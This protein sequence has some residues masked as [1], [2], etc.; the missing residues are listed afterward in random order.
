[1]TALYSLIEAAP[2]ESICLQTDNAVLTYGAFRD[3]VRRLSGGLQRHGLRRGD[4]V[5]VWLPNTIDWLVAALAFARAGIQVLGINIRFGPSE[6]GDF[7]SRATC[8]ALV[9]AP[10]HAGKDYDAVLRCIPEEQLRSLEMAVTLGS[11]SRVLANVRSFNFDELA[12]GEADGE[13]QAQG[14]DPCIVFSSSGTTSRPKL[15]IHSQERLA[16]HAMDVVR[17]FPLRGPGARVLVGV[18][19]CGAFGYTVALAGLAGHC[20]ITAPES[21]DA[22]LVVEMLDGHGITHMFGTNDMLQ[23]MLDVAGLAWRPRTLQ[24]FAHANFTPGLTALPARAEAQ[25]VH[26]RGCFGMSETFALFATQPADAPLSRRAESGGIPNCQ[27]AA[28]RVRN[29]E[30][31]ELQPAGRQGELEIFSP[32][33]ML[34]YLGDEA[35][36]AK[37]FTED[38]FFRT[39]DLAYLNDDGGFTHLSRIGDVIR[40]GGFLVNPLEIE[41]TAIQ[42]PG[43][44]ACQVV[45]VQTA[46]GSRPVAF[47]IGESGYRHDEAALIAFCKSRLAVFK[48]PVRFFE[49]DEFPVISGPNGTKVKKAELRQQALLWMERSP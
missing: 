6:I 24:T 18:P 4:G 10:R 43:L 16:R 32:N 8:K 25:G 26:L 17:A 28:V 15:I 37:A 5:A 34:G 36:T 20:S 33:V 47:V 23:R 46:Q 3:R 49:V 45:E 38:G 7:I 9:Y 22:K 40:V 12:T 30:T 31:G 1:M 48:V 35:G 29:L 11:P 42:V 44:T 13:E 14:A 19:F 39:G 41:E 27:S 21:F 2:A